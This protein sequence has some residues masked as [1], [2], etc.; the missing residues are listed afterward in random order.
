MTNKINLNPAGVS[1]GHD[2]EYDYIQE[3]TKIDYDIENLEINLE[4][5][6]LFI[7]VFIREVRGYRVLPEGDMLEFWSD[8]SRRNGWIFEIKTGG[9]K[10]LLNHRA[11][12]FPINEEGLYEYLINGASE[13]IN[14]L[15]Y[16]KPIIEIEKNSNKSVKQTD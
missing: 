9:W 10:E 16:E 6:D 4:T 2:F 3:I 7:K 5:S 14:I 1:I 15:A 13:C 12:N 8:F 11:S